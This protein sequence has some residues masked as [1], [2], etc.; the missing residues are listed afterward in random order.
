[1]CGFLR[2]C[3]SASV[4][5]SVYFCGTLGLSESVYDVFGALQKRLF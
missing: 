1:M 3:V 5:M 4:C 2:A